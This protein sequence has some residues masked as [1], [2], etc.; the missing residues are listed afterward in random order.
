MKLE[1]YISYCVYYSMQDFHDRDSMFETDDRNLAKHYIKTRG[2]NFLKACA[3]CCLDN[4]QDGVWEF[5]YGDTAREARKELRA[6]LA[7]VYGKGFY[8]I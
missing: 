4:N 1:V 6:L 5:A 3:S 8:T 7:R 2:G